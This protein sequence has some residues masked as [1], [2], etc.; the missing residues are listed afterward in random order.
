[1]LHHAGALNDLPQLQALT[2][3]DLF[4]MTAQ[5]VLNPDCLQRLERL[6]LYSVPKVYA[7]T[8]R[9]VWS[10]QIINGVALEVRQ[11]RE[12]A[13]VIENRDNPL[14]DWDGRE[15]ISSSAY[16]HTVEQLRLT[17]QAL[18]AAADAGGRRE[19]YEVI[20]RDFGIAINK[21]DR[22]RQFIETVQREELFAALQ[23]LAEAHCTQTAVA[24]EALHNV[25]EA[26]RDW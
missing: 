15:H 23:H 6:L 11:A 4:G 14:R 22:R 17:R 13:W 10:K 24:G 21:I 18:R 9:K 7:Q 5:D 3:R 26:V 19:A 1:M 12:D 8:T 16:K 25:L 20:G 2:M